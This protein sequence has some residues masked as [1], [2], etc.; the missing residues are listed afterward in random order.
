MFSSRKHLK[1]QHGGAPTGWRW[2]NMSSWAKE[3]S[4]IL[5]EGDEEEEHQQHHQ[6]EAQC[7]VRSPLPSASFCPRFFPPRAFKCLR[8][9]SFINKYE[10]KKPQTSSK[11]TDLF[12][13]VIRNTECITVQLILI[14]SNMLI[15]AVKTAEMCTNCRRQREVAHRR[16]VNVSSE[17][18]R[19]DRKR[20]HGNSGFAPHLCLSA[21]INNSKIGGCRGVRLKR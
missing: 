5:R 15:H 3:S 2:L 1:D 12:A 10:K 19:R 14:V 4:Y 11:Q 7:Q 8:K 20:Q 16:R 13:A 9:S 21:P 18:L 6:P 17:I